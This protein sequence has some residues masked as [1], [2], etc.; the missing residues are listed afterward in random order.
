MDRLG[1]LAGGRLVDGVC[2]WRPRALTFDGAACVL[3][4]M[5]DATRKENSLRLTQRH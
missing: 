2:C 5:S 3:L 4:Q 1:E